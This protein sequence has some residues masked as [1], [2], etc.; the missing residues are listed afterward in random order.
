[1]PRVSIEAESLGLQR[2]FP[3]IGPASVLGIEINP[4]AAEL[5]RVSVWIGEIQWMR[6]N[7]VGI[8]GNPILKPLEN[9]ERR[10]AVLTP[11]GTEAEWPSADAIIGNPPFLG[12]RQHRSIL[13]N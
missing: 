12:D 13:G 4:Y 10:D 7:G 5:A 9:I 1:A 8:S 2:E 3:Q 11:D 6:R